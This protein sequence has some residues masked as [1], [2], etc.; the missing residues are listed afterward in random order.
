MQ[1]THL[2]IV[3]QSSNRCL[4]NRNQLYVVVHQIVQ[5]HDPIGPITTTVL[6]QMVEII[7]LLVDRRKLRW[8][9][10]AAIW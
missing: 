4:Q 9:L 10:L 5:I 1:P 8:I 7:D 3:A 2:K 6:N